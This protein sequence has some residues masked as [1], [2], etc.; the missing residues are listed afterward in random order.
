MSESN[1]K[2]IAKNTL[3]L[4]LRMLFTM[5][6]SLYTSRVILNT[7]GVEDYGINNVVG[8]I[9]SMFSF[10][11][12]AMVTSTQRYLTYELGRGDM[13]KLQEVFSASIYVHAVISLFII[14]LVETVGMWFF[15]EKM[16]I[17][18]ER[19]EA[20]MWVFQLSI[21][22][23][24]VNVMSVPYNSAIVAHERMSA[25]A[26]ISVVEV[27][28]KLLIVYMLVIGSF[29]KLKL[30]AILTTCVSLF[31]RLIYTQY[32][33][34]H[35]EET[36]RIFR[37][38]L[39]LIKEM[40]KFAGWN[41]WGRFAGMLMGTGVNMLLNVFFGPVVNAA[42]GIAI[43]V[44]SA[45]AQFSSNFLMAV[46]PQ[47]TKLYAQNNLKDMYL[48]IYRSSKFT[49]FLLFALSLPLLLETETILKLWLKIV[50][51]YTV[52]FLRLLLII[53]V[54]DGVANPLMTSAQATGNVKVYQSVVGGILLA[55]VPFSY[56]ALKM[57]GSPGS[58]YVVY[59][60]VII[61]AFY[62]R[63]LML[64]R[65]IKLSVKEYVK[66]VIIRCVAVCL[67]AFTLMFL[68]KKIVPTGLTGSF[69]VCTMS[70][71]STVAISYFMG[72]TKGEKA[73]IISKIKAFIQK[74]DGDDSNK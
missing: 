27:L 69:I 49:C 52:Y 54:I 8:G 30:Y 51:E 9:V 45:V 33:H 23:T 18:S 44:E 46:N 50:P 67:T 72:L 42:R 43:Q 4:Y 48:L 7:L 56:M 13:K 60:T 24:V 74:K 3:L 36:R 16:V 39:A 71:L 29:D 61:I 34:R 58:V 1:N 65:M 26:M 53:V 40:G 28:L 38:D 32:S 66:E 37:P 62:V 5:A 59:L 10:I 41:L 6:V 47:I 12:G 14:I 21:L 15:Y 22:T 35:F 31:I 73:F 25:F 68:L 17:P 11:N 63:L 55:I 64:S 57:G 19:M 2:R 70:F 20:A